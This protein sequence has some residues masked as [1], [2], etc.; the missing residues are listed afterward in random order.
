MLGVGSAQHYELP[1]VI[2]CFALQDCQCLEYIASNGGM[3]DEF[4]AIYREA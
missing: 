1:V 4:E 2:S 3:N